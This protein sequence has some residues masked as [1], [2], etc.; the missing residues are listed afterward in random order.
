MIDLV[1]TGGALMHVVKVKVSILD[2]EPAVKELRENVVPMVSQL[3]GFVAGYWLEA[4][5]GKGEAFVL[6][7][8]EDAANM[9]VQ[10]IKAQ[11]A[12]GQEMSVAFDSVST[13]G[14]VAN[15]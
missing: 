8:S 5:D 3:P 2:P 9:M 12:S 1:R 6:F 13:R 14:V 4:L 15:A 10:G 11:Q 7:E